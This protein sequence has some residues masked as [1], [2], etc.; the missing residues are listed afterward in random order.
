MIFVTSIRL[1]FVDRFV[2][3]ASGLWV[4]NDPERMRVSLGQGFLVSELAL[5][6]VGP[7]A[8]GVAAK[9]LVVGQ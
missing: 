5:A 4:E 6:A 7:G 9:V 8:L 2:K 3:C 1:W